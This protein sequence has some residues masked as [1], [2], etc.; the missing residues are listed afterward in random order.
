MN[1]FDAVVIGAGAAGLMCAATAGQG[2][3][4][5]LV[6]EHAN[7]VGRKILMSG[8]GRCNFTNLCVEPDNF[9]CANPHFVKSALSRYSPWHFIEL[10]LK[11]EIPYHERDHGQLFCDKSAKDIVKLLMAEC[12]LGKVQLRTRCTVKSVHASE[13][14]YQLQTSSGEITT[15]KL[16][17]ATGGLSIPSMAPDGLGYQLAHQFGLRLLPRRAGLVPFTFSGDLKTLTES[18]SGIALPVRATVNKRSFEEALLFTHRGMSGPVILQVSNYWSEGDRLELDLLP[19]RNMQEELL[20]AKQS[21]PKSLMRTVL[22][23]LLV[24]KLVLALEARWWK[25]LAEKPLAD[26]PDKH[27]L[28]VGETLNHWQLKPAGTEGYRTAEVTL[29]GVDTDDISSKTFACKKYPNLYFIGEVLDVTGHL[30][31]YNFQWAWACGHAAGSAIA[32]E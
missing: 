3:A 26:W 1:S 25:N 30:G 22:Q 28:D 2:G 8:G 15:K 27:L 6:I 12:E 9:L 11:Y 4:R 18:L 17:V 13:T 5:V 21:S 32:Q 7:K 16:V 14:G 20:Q 10:V 23:P 31:G 19:Q 24:K 29:G